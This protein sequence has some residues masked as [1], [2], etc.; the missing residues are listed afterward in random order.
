MVKSKV[1]KGCWN[2]SI[3]KQTEEFLNSDALRVGIDKSVEKTT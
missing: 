3:D 1:W 2:A